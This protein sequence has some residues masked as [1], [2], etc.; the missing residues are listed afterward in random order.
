MSTVLGLILGLG[1][2]L[3]AAP[4]LWPASL[5][6]AAERRT[7]RI[8]SLLDRAGLEKVPVSVFLATSVCLG[9]VAA[10]VAEASLAVLALD[11]AAAVVGLLLPIWVVRHRGRARRRA[12]HTFWPDAVDHLVSA[13]RSGVALPDSVSALAHA[14]P[15]SGRAAFAEFEATYRTTGNFGVSLDALKVRLADPTADRILETL[16]MSREVGG[17]DLTRVLRSLSG[18]L[19]E[20]A[21]IRSEVE[22]R[23]SWVM[24]AARLGVAAPWIVLLLLS[25]RP[26]AAAAYNSAGGVVLIVGGLCLS[27]IAYRVMLVIARIPEERRWFA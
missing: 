15:V 25:T 6:P 23:Q 20:D 1:L 22:A 24:N 8:R 11:A 14:G 10:A 17:T 5:E 27:I 3:C 19:R 26:E 9:L 18:Y 13:V 21:A 2:V 12:S 16:R 7:G 4:F